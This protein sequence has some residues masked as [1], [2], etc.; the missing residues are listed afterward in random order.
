[1][2]R[3][4]VSVYLD[5]AA[6][7]RLT[8]PRGMVAQRVTGITR[9][10]LIL[11]EATAPVGRTMEIKRSHKMGTGSFNQYG[12]SHRVTN[13]APHAK[14]VLGGTPALIFSHGGSKMAVGKSGGEPKG[15]WSWANPIRGQRANNWLNDAKVTVM[16]RH[17]L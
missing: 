9:E 5:N 6:L 11:A 14:Y 10:V 3:T 4:T 2:A 8:L 15:D 12:Y 1:M 13:T 16:R 17:G 7:D